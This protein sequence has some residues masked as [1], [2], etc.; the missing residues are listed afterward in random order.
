MDHENLTILVADDDIPNRLILQAILNK[1]GFTVL[2]AD[3]GVQ[4]VDIFDRE[5]PDLVLMDIKMPNMDG[6]EATRYIK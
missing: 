6:Y 2:H 3:D 4:A 1:Q 5:R